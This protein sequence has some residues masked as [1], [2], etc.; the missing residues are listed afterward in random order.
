MKPKPF[1][2]GTTIRDYEVLAQIGSGGIGRVLLARRRGPHG[3]EKL[4][5]IKTLRYDDDEWVHNHAMFLDEARLAARLDHPAIAQV[6]DFWVEAGRCY[7]VMEYIRGAPVSRLLQ[8]LGQPLPVPV[9]I[10]LAARVGL[11][12]HAAHETRDTDGTHLGVVHRDVSPQ[13]VMLSTNGEVKLIDFGIALI[14]QRLTPRTEAGVIKGKPAYMAPEQLKHGGGDARSDTYA[15][16]VVLYEMLTYKRLFARETLG[17]TVQ[18]VLND[19]VLAP[20][21]INRAISPDVD[22][23]VMR[24][25]ARDPDRRFRSASDMAQALKSVCAEAHTVTLAQFAS[26]TLGPELEEHERRL[27]G[28]RRGDVHRSEGREESTVRARPSGDS[29]AASPTDNTPLEP[30][31][32]EAPPRQTRHRLQML[33]L[34]AGAALALTVGA[35]W[36]ARGPTA[37][38]DKRGAGNVRATATAQTDGTQRP[39]ATRLAATTRA[40]AERRDRDSASAERDT[41]APDDSASSSTDPRASTPALQLAE[42]TTRPRENPRQPSATHRGNQSRR[43][44]SAAARRSPMRRRKRSAAARRSAPPQLGYLTVAA[45]PYANVF[46][47][48]K[49]RGVT[50]LRRLELSAGL[51]QLLL[52]DPETGAVLT[53]RRLEIAP[54]REHRVVHRQ[55]P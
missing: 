16:G 19:P 9:A 39:D 50:P 43:K 5:A 26:E 3:F 41:S 2:P 42:P 24:A 48:G 13:N 52:R 37:S 47:D 10:A 12:L 11:A 36:L 22:R 28:R 53:R 29:R 30:T 7:L 1:E 14:S 18:A 23:V 4:V 40:S 15:L 17:A 27:A 35:I 6:Y 21:H 31:L 49:S 20:S 51:H 54:D 45:E 55:S 32:G 33:G 8:R 44:R 38:D 46:I 25:I 34:A